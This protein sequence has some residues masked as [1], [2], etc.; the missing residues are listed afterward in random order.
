MKHT[1]TDSITFSG[2]LQKTSKGAVSSAAHH[3]VSASHQPHRKKKRKKERMSVENRR[4]IKG[5]EGE[6]GGGSDLAY[7]G[8]L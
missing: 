3:F 4:G 8:F 7:R 5:F 1:V 6:R 2:Y